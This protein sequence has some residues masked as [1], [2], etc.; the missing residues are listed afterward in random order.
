MIRIPR[1]PEMKGMSELFSN[2]VY[3]TATGSELS[4]D[5]ISPWAATQTGKELRYP[6]VVFIQGSAWTFPVTGFEIP[7]LARLAS[8][9]FVV[10]TVRHR[11]IKDGF[12]APAFLQDVKCAIRFLRANAKKYHIDSERV[13]AWGTSSGGNTALL[14]GLTG[15]DPRFRTE[16]YSEYSD[17]VSGVA[18]CFGPANL[19]ELLNENSD[20]EA[21]ELLRAFCGNQERQELLRL[22]SPVNYVKPGKEYVPFLLIHGDADPVVPFSQSVEMA[23]LLEDAGAKVDFICVEGAE[24]EGTFWSFA[25]YDMIDNFFMRL[26]YPTDPET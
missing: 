13:Y 18:E 24:H 3:S 22:L 17:H 21:Q 14:L 1:N 5:L 26:A 12:C 4:M 10:A 9:G 11:S 23:A 19:P 16:E 8:K 15:D 20:P 7:Q 2:I 25:L 6:L